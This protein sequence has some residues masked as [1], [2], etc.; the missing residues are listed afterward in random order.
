MIEFKKEM[1]F[2][3]IFNIFIIDIMIVFVVLNV[4]IWSVVVGFLINLNK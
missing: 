3:S 1:V 2:I 4:M